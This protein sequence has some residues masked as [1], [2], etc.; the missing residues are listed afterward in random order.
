M[1]I[2]AEIR[3]GD[4]VVAFTCAR[5]ILVVE[6]EPSRVGHVE[7]FP[8]QRQILLVVP[9]HVPVLRKPEVDAEVA[10]ATYEI[11]YADLTGQSGIE[12]SLGRGRIGEEVHVAVGHVV[13][14]A[15][16]MGHGRH[17]RTFPIPVGWVVGGVV[18][19]GVRESARPTEQTG[20]L[21]ASDRG[22]DRAI[23]TGGKWTALSEGEVNNPIRIQLMRSIK[24]G[25]GA[26]KTGGPGIEH[27]TAAVEVER[28]SVS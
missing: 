4:G 6:V 2:V 21:P 25:N 18:V 7:H 5:G 1:R 22:I 19:D 9:W 27:L 12:Q 13:S 8:A 3:D 23:D 14:T 16:H 15:F 28:A 24:I 11:A 20:E 26:E 17:C 10:I